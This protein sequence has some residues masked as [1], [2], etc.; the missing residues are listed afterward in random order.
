MWC[1]DQGCAERGHEGAPA[2]RRLR[3]ELKGGLWGK[4]FRGSAAGRRPAIASLY[5]RLKASVVTGV[6]TGVSG[7]CSASVAARREWRGKPCPTICLGL[8]SPEF[9]A[10]ADAS[11]WQV[12]SASNRQRIPWRRII[13]KAFVQPQERILKEGGWRAAVK[14]ICQFANALRCDLCNPLDG[15]GKPPRKP[16]P[17]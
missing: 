10:N 12:V 13:G 7:L 17:Q 3:V 4:A 14:E 5:S 1:R 6:E 16:G 8:F 2:G 15:T 11:A 9:L